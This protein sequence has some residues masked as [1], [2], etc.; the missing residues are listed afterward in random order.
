MHFVSP[1]SKLFKA[2]RTAIMEDCKKYELDE[3]ELEKHLYYAI[4]GRYTKK[5]SIFQLLDYYIIYDTKGWCILTKCGNLIFL[6]YM[7]V[8][9]ENDFGS[10]FRKL[11]GTWEKYPV[12]VRFKTKTAAVVRAA[13]SCGF[14]LKN[15]ASEDK[16]LCFERKF[17]NTKKD[18]PRS[19]TKSVGV[20]AL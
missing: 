12:V 8:Y 1:K 3:K 2:A 20:E 10:W 17:R 13:H 6:E 16:R 19:T 18:S 15:Q 7:F 11:L 14:R 9:P 4:N 5:T